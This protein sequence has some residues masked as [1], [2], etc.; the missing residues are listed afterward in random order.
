MARYLAFGDWWTW[1]LYQNGFCITYRWH[2]WRCSVAKNMGGNRCSPIHRLATR[3]LDFDTLLS[4]YLLLRHYRSPYWKRQKDIDP[5]ACRSI[6]SI[7][8]AV[9]PVK[10]T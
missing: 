1:P 3:I 4:I 10:P 5:G 8:Y 7:E 2:C 9:H 6:I